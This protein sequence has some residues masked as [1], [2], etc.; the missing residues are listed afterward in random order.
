MAHSLGDLNNSFE[1]LRHELRLLKYPQAQTMTLETFAEGLPPVFLPIIHHTLLEYS[2]LIS[3]YITEVGF[4]L[5]AKNDLRFIEST[6]KLL[7]TQ[8]NYKPSITVQ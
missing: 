2:P 4:D 7:L 8:F 5:Y 1:K 3:A 6:Y